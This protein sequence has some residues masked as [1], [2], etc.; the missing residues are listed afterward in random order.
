MLGGGFPSPCKSKKSGGGQN[1]G[2]KKK[3]APNGVRKNLFFWGALCTRR[4]I[5]VFYISMRVVF[6]QIGF[7]FPPLTFKTFCRPTKI[8]TALFFLGYCLKL[9]G[10]NKKGFLETPGEE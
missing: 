6:F 10:E 4:G 3:N 1:I 7:I 8:K 2:K 9:V 5:F